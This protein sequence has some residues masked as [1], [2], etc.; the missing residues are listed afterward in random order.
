MKGVK[1]CFPDDL[2]SLDEIEKLVWAK[3]K[4]LPFHFQ[5]PVTGM[6]FVRGKEYPSVKRLD[7]FPSSQAM[8]GL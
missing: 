6:Q 4:T 3:M 5:H 2:A 7:L 8:E 1:K